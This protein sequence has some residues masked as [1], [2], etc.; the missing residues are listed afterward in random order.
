M[1]M[2][3]AVP[4]EAEQQLKIFERKLRRESVPGTVFDQLEAIYST[5]KRT[6]MPEAIY[7]KLAPGYELAP[8]VQYPMI[9]TLSAEA[10]EGDD[11]TLG[12]LE[13][14]EE[15]LVTKFG[16]A[17]AND[18]AH[19]VPCNEYGI[20]ANTKEAFQINEQAVDLL[21]IWGKEYIERSR[22]QS[23]LERI[24][25]NLQAAPHSLSPMITPNVYVAGLAD[26]SQPVCN[27]LTANTW[28]NTVG[29]ALAASSSTAGASCSTLNFFIRLDNWASTQKYIEPVMIGGKETY[30]FLL[31]SSQA[32]YLK[33]PSGTG[34][35]GATWFQMQKREDEEQQFNTMLG[36]I[37]RIL[38]IEYPRFPTVT[39]SGSSGAYSLTTAY[40]GMGRGTSSDP[41]DTT[42]AGRD[43]GL[44]LG[45]GSI[46]ERKDTDWH[47][48]YQWDQYDKFFGV[49]SACTV[50]HNMPVYN[51]G[52]KTV[53]AE[54]QDSSIACFFRKTPSSFI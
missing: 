30:I 29:T 23:L 9:K 13:G 50:G 49:A 51:L 28:A 42:S 21:A 39:L 14:H 48:E 26:A 54:Q 25:Q 45:K 11:S 33:S 24:G 34:S 6:A 47:L 4:L 46:I 2:S 44:L 18:V 19:A 20:D 3:L 17:R 5:S 1:S 41:R 16:Q 8:V 12:N 36:R 38:I 40:R 53:A 52:T 37:G 10:T 31:P 43:V 27:S 7:Y 22:S 32:V 15:A 35:L